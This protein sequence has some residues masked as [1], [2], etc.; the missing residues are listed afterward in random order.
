MKNALYLTAAAVGVYGLYLLY[1]ESQKTKA[2]KGTTLLSDRQPAK[3]KWPGS[4]LVPDSMLEQ[5]KT[6]FTDLF[7]TP[8]KLVSGATSTDDMSTQAAD[9]IVR[10]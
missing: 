4:E 9:T 3:E 5:F 10:Q 7:N 2:P 8:H 1:K 6:G